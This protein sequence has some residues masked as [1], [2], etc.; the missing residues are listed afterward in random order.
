MINILKQAHNTKHIKN[1][2]KTTQYKETSLENR[3]RQTQQKL[4]ISKQ[5]HNTKHVKNDN[6]QNTVPT[7][8][9]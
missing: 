3:I 2:T 5:Q 6:T 4:T 9:H 7:T 8:Q 1:N